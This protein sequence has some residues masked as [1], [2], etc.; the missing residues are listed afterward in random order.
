MDEINN[1]YFVSVW[2]HVGV[3]TVKMHSSDGVM[4]M[5]WTARFTYQ[6]D[7][8]VVTDNEMVLWTV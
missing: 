6:Y 7:M 3:F 2:V 5:R 4:Y 1:A 8:Y